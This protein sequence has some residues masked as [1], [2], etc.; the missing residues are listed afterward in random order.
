MNS[1]NL[2]YGDEQPN[3]NGNEQTE[4]TD[5]TREDP[6]YSG[7]LASFMTFLKKG[8]RLRCQQA[9]AYRQILGWGKNDFHTRGYEF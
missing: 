4:K 2:T 7:V 1:R 9:D 8:Q 6:Q 3:E 5:N